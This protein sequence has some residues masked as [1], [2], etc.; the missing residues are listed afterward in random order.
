MKS[1]PGGA[2]ALLLAGLAA[3]GG[4]DIPEVPEVPTEG[5]EPAVRMAVES[6][7]R[8]VEEN[9]TSAARWGRLGMVL[10]AHRLTEPARTAYAE[11]ARQDTEDHRWPHLEGRLV[12]ASDPAAALIRADEAVSRNPFF[13]PALALRA[14]V[15]DALGRRGEADGAWAEL[16]RVDPDS[17]EANLA[18]GRSLLHGGDLDAARTALERVVAEGPSSEA[19]WAFLAQVYRRLGE[20]RLAELA[21]VRARRAAASP[22]RSGSQDPDPLLAAVEELRADS[23]GREARARRAAASGD[24]AAAVAIYERLA[25]ERPEE[26]ELHY[27]LGNALTRQGDD[28]AAE[29]AYRAALARDPTSIPAMANLANLVARQGRDGEAAALYRASAAADPEHVPTLLGASSLHFQQGSLRDAERLLRQVLTLDPTHPAALQGLGQLLATAGNPAGA[30]D[31]LGQAL[32]VA[33]ESGAPAAR[34]AELHFLLADV[35]RRRGR[36]DE[37]VFHLNRAETLGMEI[38]A[39][40]REGLRGR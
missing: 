35:A 16:L 1:S 18:R 3:C 32:A 21:A 30:A 9:R 14:R 19:A 2:A 40:F 28:G 33:E 34:R 39:A 38:P 24:H 36:A 29:A 4:G 12:E 20:D 25:A 6:A 37:A 10:H 23:R 13:S 27:N 22:I 7:L 15:L 26:A 5:M 11:A 8:A 17:V 31:A